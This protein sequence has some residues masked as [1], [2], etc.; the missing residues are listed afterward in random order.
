MKFFVIIYVYIHVGRCSLTKVNRK[1]FSHTLFSPFADVYWFMIFE[2]PFYLFNLKVKSAKG[3]CIQK[4]SMWKS[5]LN[6]FVNFYGLLIRTDLTWICHWNLQ[7]LNLSRY[8]LLIICLTQILF[9]IHKWFSLC[10]IPRYREV[11]LAIIYNGAQLHFQLD[12]SYIGGLMHRDL[13]I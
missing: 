2:S 1:W 3:L 4:T 13:N 6:K 11:T 9:W 7:D 10:A 8:S 5:F 12:L